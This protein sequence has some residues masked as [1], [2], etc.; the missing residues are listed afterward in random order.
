M[1]IKNE[2]LF[3]K[4]NELLNKLRPNFQIDGGNIEIAEITDENVVKLKWVGSCARC[5]RSDITFKYSV[6]EFLL[7]ELPEIKDVIEL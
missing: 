6:R 1:K 3:N 7:E 4:I 2:L 5:E